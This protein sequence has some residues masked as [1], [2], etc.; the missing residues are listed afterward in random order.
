ND[1][2]I[3]GK[4]ENIN[5][6]VDKGTYS[7]SITGRDKTGELI[8]SYIKPKQYKHRNFKN[9]IEAV[10]KDNGFNFK[11]IQD[12][13]LLK[14]IDKID[15]GGQDKIFD[16]LD[17]YAKK[18]QVLLFT[19]EDGDLVITREG[20]DLAVNKLTSDNIINST[21][22]SN[23]SE[24]YRFIDVYG[25]VKNNFTSKRAEQKASIINNL[26]NTNKRLIVKVENNSSYKT[27]N[28]TANWYKNVKQAKGSKYE[29]SVKGHSQNGLL[30]KP[31][32]I[33]NLIDKRK[34]INGTFLIQ[35]VKYRSG[36]DG[37]ITDLSIVNLGSFG[38]PPINPLLSKLIASGKDLATRFK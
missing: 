25:S 18:A 16:F 27:L 35:G 17:T 8:D 22:Q 30:W 38:L 21:L 23:S 4:I 36:A 34:S 15:D 13:P 10:L 37:D 24:N 29:C 1:K 9:L 14:L 11:I 28:L 31:N 2:I 7:L 20:S 19:D 26:S 32:S 12:V 3:T 5:D 33:V 6:K